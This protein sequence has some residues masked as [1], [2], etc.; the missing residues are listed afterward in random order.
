MPKAAAWQT[1]G[2]PPKMKPRVSSAARTAPRTSC[3]Y[4][5]VCTSPGKTTTLFVSI[6]MRERK[7]GCFILAA[8]H[9]L[10]ANEPGRDIPSPN[11]Y[12]ARQH[13]G[14]DHQKAAACK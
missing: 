11:G 6:Q 13:Q 2:I 1:A 8:L 7:R 5:G 4:P 10:Q 9:R 12:F 3:G 14:A